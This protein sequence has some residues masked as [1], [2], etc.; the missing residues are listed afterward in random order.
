M[1]W[2]DYVLFCIMLPLPVC[3]IR[4]SDGS[5]VRRKQ[6][7]QVRQVKGGP[8]HHILGAGLWDQDQV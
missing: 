7:A 1:V 6:Y 5:P 3:F 2:E 4:K 8:K